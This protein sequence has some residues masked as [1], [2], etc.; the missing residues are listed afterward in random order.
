[1]R[2]LEASRIFQAVTQRTV[3]AD[4]GKPNEGDGECDCVIG[5]ICEYE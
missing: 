2:V 3:D 5:E 4:M 1:M